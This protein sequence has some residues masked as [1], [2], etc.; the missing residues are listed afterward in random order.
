MEYAKTLD[1]QE[2]KEKREKLSAAERD[3]QF[4]YE[5]PEGLPE[6]EHASIWITNSKGTPVHKGEIDVKTG[7]RGV[8]SWNG[9]DRSGARTC[10][11]AQPWEKAKLDFSIRWTHAKI[12]PGSILCNV[13]S[14]M[15]FPSCFAEVTKKNGSAIVPHVTAAIT[16]ISLNK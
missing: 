5:I 12:F 16:R 11:L 14:A 4:S 8:Y 13:R 1:S 7:E 15:Q 10:I 2:I 3:V 9:L 6:L